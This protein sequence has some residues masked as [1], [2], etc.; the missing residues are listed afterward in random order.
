MATSDNESDHLQPS[1]EYYVIFVAKM[2]CKLRCNVWWGLLFSKHSK[3]YLNPIL[4]HAQCYLALNIVWSVIK[5][6]CP[7]NSYFMYPPCSRHCV[8]TSENSDAL[9]ISSILHSAIDL[10]NRISLHSV[11]ALNIFHSCKQRNTTVL[12]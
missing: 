4:C 5:P 12:F 1:R 10:L 8:L 2:L 3:F 9:V 6:V 11:S 7:F